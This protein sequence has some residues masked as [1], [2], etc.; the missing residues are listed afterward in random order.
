M[1]MPRIWSINNATAFSIILLLSILLLYHLLHSLHYKRVKENS[2]YVA[3]VCILSWSLGAI[4]NIFENIVQIVTDDNQQLL[5]STITDLSTTILD[6]WCL[7][8]STYFIKKRLENAFKNT[9]LEINKLLINIVFHSLFVFPSIVDVLCRIYFRLTRKPK[10][11]DISYRS[12]RQIGFP[13]VGTFQSVFL[14]VTLVF[15]NNRLYRF[16][17]LTMKNN[18]MLSTEI[19]D[20]VRALIIKQTTLIL[21][22]ILFI[23]FMQLF[24]VIMGYNIYIKTWLYCVR[25]VFILINMYLTLNHTNQYYH[26]YYKYCHMFFN[27]ICMKFIAFRN[28]NKDDY[29]Q[30][31][32][33]AH[34]DHPCV[35]LLI[36]DMDNICVNITD[37][38]AVSRICNLLRKYTELKPT[39]FKRVNDNTNYFVVDIVNDFNHILSYHDS[40]S[41]FHQIYHRLNPYNKHENYQRCHHYSRYYARRTP[42]DY[43]ESHEDE[44]KNTTHTDINNRHHD[45]VLSSILNKI[46]SFYYHS[47]DTS[48]RNDPNIVIQQKPKYKTSIINKFTSH[49]GENDIN[50]GD[51]DVYSVGKRFEYVDSENDWFVSPKYENFKQELIDNAICNININCYDIEYSKYQ[52]YM[53]T[54][55]V[56]KLKNKTNTNKLLPEYI[57]CI[58]IYCNCHNYQNKWSSTFRSIPHKENKSSLKQ[59]HSYFYFSSK[60][61]R[62]LVEI[63]GENLVNAY[64]NSTFYHGISEILYFVR[65]ATQFNGPLS[66]STEVNVATNFTN[67]KGIVLQLKYL[68]STY[69]LKSKYFICSSLSDYPNEKEHLFIGGIPMM[70]ITNII[71]ISNGEQYQKYISAINLITCIFNGTHIRNDDESRNE[72][73]FELL[74]YQ[75]SLN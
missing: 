59:R 64:D 37:C 9:N 1:A 66:T 20:A 21:T 70:S 60:Y 58:L 55:H 5:I 68:F 2:K 50:N 23:I 46:H 40:P 28:R 26:K 18:Q 31:L 69:P 43:D 65:I 51:T 72:C 45:I 11:I 36:M 62:N 12:Y 6:S 54:D 16:I 48:M 41:D 75:L 57:L 34:N 19:N 49:L 7:I 56:L 14:L 10:Q 63:F 29:S 33:H 53:Q 61:L 4:A 67:N 13:I 27:F 17:S 39:E 44:C 42:T 24:I 32:L 22:I 71:N 25:N 15:V 3:V 38:D 30:S 35:K 8:I 47:Y 73:C 52:Q 74:S